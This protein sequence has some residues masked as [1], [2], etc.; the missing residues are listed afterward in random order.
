MMA[1]GE[2]TVS[3]IECIDRGYEKL[4]EKLRNLGADIRR[5]TN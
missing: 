2:T 5:V 1:H 4:E 3:N